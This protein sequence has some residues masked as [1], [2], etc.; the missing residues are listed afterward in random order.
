M[1]KKRN[2]DKII[3]E[4]G[5]EIVEYLRGWGAYYKNSISIY[6]KH[7]PSMY[8]GFM[9]TEDNK[10]LVV[11]EMDRGL[12]GQMCEQ[13]PKVFKHKEKKQAKAYSKRRLRYR[14]SQNIE[15]KY[16]KNLA[17]KSEF[18]R[19]DYFESKDSDGKR[20]RMDDHLK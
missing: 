13:F 10:N 16:I 20:T 5:I 12:Y 3:K 14:L 19:R 4:S 8:V 15:G 17:F 18:F 2:L 11:V 6:D 1:P 7:S 9:P